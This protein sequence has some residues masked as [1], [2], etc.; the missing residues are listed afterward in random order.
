MSNR[1]IQSTSGFFVA[2]YSVGYSVAHTV[3][4]I[5]IIVLYNLRLNCTIEQV[6]GA[7][8]LVSSIN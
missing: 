4:L 2:W 6:P 5:V 1:I 7:V 8:Y 3:H